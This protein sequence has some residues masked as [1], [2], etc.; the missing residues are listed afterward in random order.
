MLV[1]GSR[2]ARA[3]YL[4]HYHLLTCGAYFFPSLVFIRPYLAKG[5]PYALTMLGEGLVKGEEGGG[6]LILLD[7]FHIA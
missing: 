5:N 7:L 6:V 4:T 3:G 2:L 1:G